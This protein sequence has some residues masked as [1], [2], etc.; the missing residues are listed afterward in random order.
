MCANYT[1][2]CC[3]LGHSVHKEAQELLPSVLMRQ[4]SCNLWR[5]F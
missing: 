3:T 1:V 2:Y 4:C 5:T